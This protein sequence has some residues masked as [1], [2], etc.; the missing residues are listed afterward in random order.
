MTEGPSRQVKSS[1]TDVKTLH[2]EIHYQG[3]SCTHCRTKS[4]PTSELTALAGKTVEITVIEVPIQR[5]WRLLVWGANPSSEVVLHQEVGSGYSWQ[6]TPLWFITSY[7][8]V[9]VAKMKRDQNYNILLEGEA[10]SA[11]TKLKTC[12]CTEFNG[13]GHLLWLFFKTYVCQS[14]LIKV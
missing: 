11:S 3:R 1:C 4:I 6:Q 8:T 10:C 12:A 13:C 7:C 5:D 9:D 2:F 14:L